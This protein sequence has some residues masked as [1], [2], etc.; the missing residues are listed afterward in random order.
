MRIAS[1]YVVTGVY[2]IAAAVN[3]SFVLDKKAYLT[4]GFLVA[5]LV[6]AL[7]TLIILWTTR[8]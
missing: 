2:F 4:A 8:R 6:L 3:L 7:V 1:I 5:Y